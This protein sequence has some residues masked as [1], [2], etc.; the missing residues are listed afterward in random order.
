MKSG[1][2]NENKKHGTDGFPLELYCVDGTHPQY[3]MPLHRHSEFEIIAVRSGNM[4]LYLG[5]MEYLLRGGDI[6]FVNPLVLHR[7]EPEDCVYECLVFDLNILR[8]GGDDVS[9][10]VLPII[11]GSLS[12][13]ALADAGESAVCRS[14]ESLLYSARSKKY[15]SGLDI[16]ARIFTLFFELY[17]SGNIIK[18]AP[19]K[20][21]L[22][23][24]ALTEI[25]D[26]IEDNLGEKITLSELASR[27]GFNEKYFCR[28][29]KAFTGKTPIE[30][31]NE[32]RIGNACHLLL[33]GKKTVTE[34]AM[35]SGFSDMS[36]FSKIFKRYRH[37]TPRQMQRFANTEKAKSYLKF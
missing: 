16:I 33:Q 18:A 34:A 23:S 17:S 13:N 12:V 5:G 28:I 21:N 1:D 9:A 4:K 2:F 6:A 29:F 10:L 8:R 11:K 24:E 25:L 14:A 3:E 35:L 19:S 32:I 26:Y 27:A 37:C 36:Y 30:Y 22:H 7:N 31:I 15:F 20:S